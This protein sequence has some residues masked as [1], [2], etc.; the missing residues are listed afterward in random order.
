MRK[1][2]VTIGQDKGVPFINVYYEDKRYRFWNGKAIGINLQSKNEPELLKA[3][4]ELEIRNGWKPKP[5]KKAVKEIPI[6]V[7]QALQKGIDAKK[8]QSC[9]E[10]FLKDAERIVTLWQRYERE[11]YIKLGISLSNECGENGRGY[12][13]RI[14][15]IDPK[16]NE[17]H[18]NRD[19]D[20]ITKRGYDGVS[21]G[22]LIYLM[23]HYNVI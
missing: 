10:R 20:D 3:A 12:Y 6:T 21:K 15:R 14:C 1:L 11:E 22:T 9:S 17:E 18:C 13:H 16:Y 4:F 23:Q 19:F 8:A 5:K 2:N 7:L